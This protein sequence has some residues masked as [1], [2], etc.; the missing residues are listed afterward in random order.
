M[1]RIKAQRAGNGSVLGK[2]C[3]TGARQ[4]PSNVKRNIKA[5]TPKELLDSLKPQ[6]GQHL[7]TAVILGLLAG[8]VIILQAWLLAR[9]I[10]GVIF[11]AQT[12]SDVWLLLALLLGLFALRFSLTWAS[13]RVAFK[14]AADVKHTLRTRLYGQ[15]TKIGPVLRDDLTAA[16]VSTSLLEGIE[17]LEAYFSRYLPAMSLVALIPLSIV[18]VILPFDW[19]SALIM[20]LTAPLIPIFMIM[21]G[22]G[23][24]RL[25]QRQWKKLALMSGHFLD[26]IQGLTTL[27][28]FNASR[29]E[30]QTVAAISD[31]YGRET[32]VVLRVAFLSS[33]VLEFVATVSIAMIA[34]TIGFRLLFG[35]MDFLY[36]FYVLLLAPEFYLPLRSMG[37]HYHARMEA[38]GAAE[39]IALALDT[40]ID[41]AREI[42]SEHR[43]QAPVKI[44]ARELTFHY[45]GARVALQQLDFEIAAGERVAIV[46]PSGAGK[47][48]LANLLLG[49]ITPQAGALLFN[50]TDVRSLALATRQAL[51][52][53]VPQQPRLFM[54]TIADNIRL[55]NPAASDAEVTAAAQQAAAHDFITRLNQGYATPTGELGAGLSGGEIQRIALARAFL[56]NAPILLLD[57]ATASLDPESEAA[58]TQAM[59]A[60]RRDTT[61]IVI[62]HRLTTVTRMDRILVMDQGRVVQAGTHTALLAEAGL[63][64]TL[65]QSYGFGAQS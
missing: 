60:I 28:L 1:L 8:W 59:E 42:E 18:A 14:A 40:P 64:R 4:A 17:A 2:H 23:T 46:G 22:K 53:W 31:D 48:T 15:I 38:I 41:P 44:T 45:P 33:A 20:L 50:D 56:K 47:S 29:R 43:I 9:V 27:K 25:N 58:I 6:A 39:N 24:E 35:H 65:V 7:R 19:K 52:S 26:M 37:T 30:A 32:M 13:E 49:F 61:L 10:N 12:L 57:E 62:A 5:M 16:T 55:G 11:D 36:G 3:N 21:I 63:Y 51:I 54:G 34:V